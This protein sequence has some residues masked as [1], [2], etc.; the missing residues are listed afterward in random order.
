MTKKEK[1]KLLLTCTS[2][3]ANGEQIFFDAFPIGEDEI[4]NVEIE[5]LRAKIKTAFDKLFPVLKEKQVDIYDK[6]LSEETIDEAITFYTTN[7][8]QEIISNTPHINREVDA[9]G[10]GL[11]KELFQEMQ[12]D[13]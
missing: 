8:G 2:A 5:E 6:W 10:I 4:G 9:V 7:A 3:D 12:K 13:E 1:I 11:V